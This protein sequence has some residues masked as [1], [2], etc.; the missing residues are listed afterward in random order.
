MMVTVPESFDE[1]VFAILSSGLLSQPYKPAPA[2]ATAEPA[3]KFLRFI[4]L[5]LQSQIS[6]KGGS[7]RLHSRI[8]KLNL[9]SSVFDCSLLPD[10][11]IETVLLHRAIPIRIRVHPVIFTRRRSI[12][13]HPEANRFPALC[14]SQHQ[15]Q[16]TRME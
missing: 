9:K 4:Y 11:L 12:D 14:R 7:K 2:T 5:F 13:L 1:L 10:Q 15:V 16:I 6:S 3:R 8:K